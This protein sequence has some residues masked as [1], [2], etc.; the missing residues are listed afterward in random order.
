MKEISNDT[1]GFDTEAYFAAQMDSFTARIDPSVP[2]VIEFGGK[3]FGDYHAARVLPGYDPHVKADIIQGL[4]DTMGRTELALVVN[5]QDLLH[6]PDGRRVAKRVRGDTQL[7]Y[8]EEILRMADQADREFGL[9]VD[10]VVVSVVPR[11]LVPVNEDYLGGFADRLAA[12]FGRVHLLP[13]VDGYPNAIPDDQV[14]TRLT[15]VDPIAPH[16]NLVLMSAGGGSGKFGVAASEIAHH[17]ETGIVPNFIKF[18]TFPVFAL[19]EGHP[20]NQAFL[21]ATADLPNELTTLVNGLTNY[22]KDVENLALLRQMIAQYPHLSTGRLEFVEPTDMGVNVI[23]RGITDV[24]IVAA[25]CRAEIGRRITRYEQEVSRG[26]EV[27]DT[28]TRTQQYAAHLALD[29]LIA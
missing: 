8:D 10:N 25:A 12:N 18:E 24:G 1:T 21:A 4:R 27:P 2:N 6:D 26:V 20:L 5:A 17:L 3:P 9:T 19:S 14:V 22:S 29:Q 16:S 28:L 11:G 23:E 13:K 7:T 15:E